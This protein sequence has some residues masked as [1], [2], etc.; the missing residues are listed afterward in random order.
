MVGF[1]FWQNGLN[2]LCTSNVSNRPGNHLWA[3]N[4]AGVFNF[5]TVE[6]YGNHF[7]LR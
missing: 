1:L 3:M 4:L 7:A 2:V 6:Q 5:A